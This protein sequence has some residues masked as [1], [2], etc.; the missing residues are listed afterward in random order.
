[1]LRP[2]PAGFYHRL[3]IGSIVVL[4]HWPIATSLAVKEVMLIAL[5]APGEVL[6]SASNR[7]R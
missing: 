7:S 1:V 4:V 2:V 5:G 3:R 6:P